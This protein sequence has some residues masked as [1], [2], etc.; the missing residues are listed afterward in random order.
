MNLKNEK[1]QIIINHIINNNLN[2]DEVK[3]FIEG[4]NSAMELIDQKLNLEELL[5]SKNNEALES[6]GTHV[7][8]L[9][10]QHKKVPV[11]VIE[12]IE[13]IEL[14]N[15]DLMS[16]IGQIKGLK[17]RYDKEVK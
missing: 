11:S 10:I 4:F 15:R 12:T 7:K 17:E 8:K 13:T 1:N 3:A 2:S 9:E 16:Y 14:F 5:L 6:L